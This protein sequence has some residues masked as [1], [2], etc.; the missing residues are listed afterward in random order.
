LLAGREFWTAQFELASW[1][2][3]IKELSYSVVSKLLA[4][5]SVDK[6][7]LG[8]S[9]ESIAR[10]ATLLSA[11]CHSAEKRDS[12]E[13]RENAVAARSGEQPS[14]SVLDRPLASHPTA[15]NRQQV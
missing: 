7:V 6:T 1:T 14:R 12:D 9:D 4:R 2:P 15:A 8:M 11:F 13:E 3:Q 5:G 10:A